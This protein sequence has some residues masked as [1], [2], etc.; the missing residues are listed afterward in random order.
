MSIRPVQRP[1]GS[2]FTVRVDD[3]SD[4][5]AGLSQVFDTD[6]AWS[7]GRLRELG[8]P[9]RTYLVVLEDGPFAGEEWATSTLPDELV[10]DFTAG[11]YVPVASSWSEFF[12]D[13][14][15]A[16]HRYVWLAAEA[17]G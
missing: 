3:G 4:G 12:D 17:I 13:R 14:D 10:T 1:D 7:L 16:V 2:W 6:R 5:L 11:R 15:G 8:V 9:E